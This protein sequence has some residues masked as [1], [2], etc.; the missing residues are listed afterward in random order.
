[1]F[2][3]KNNYNN[4]IALGFLITS[5]LFNSI[6][7]EF[8][9]S[10]N[11]NKYFNIQFLLIYFFSFN[12]FIFFSI[13]PL[14]FLGLVNDSIVGSPFG[15]SSCIY[16]LIY[17]IAV[18][19]NTIKLRSIFKAEWLA[20]GISIFAAYILI[21]IIYYFMGN[22]YDFRMLI[23]NFLGTFFIYPISWIFLKYVFLKM[24]TVGNE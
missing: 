15:M 19:Q 7:D 11:L 1:M 8:S 12:R 6:F 20:F 9:L 22:I 17:K 13:I 14:F 24:E 2:R 23:Y 21:V 5:I 4:I 10:A 16:I 3:A 18:Y